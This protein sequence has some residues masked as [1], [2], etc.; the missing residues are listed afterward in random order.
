MKPFPHF[1]VFI[2]AYH[3]FV[4]SYPS[5]GNFNQLVKCLDYH[6]AND[7]NKYTNLLELYSDFIKD[8]ILNTLQRPKVGCDQKNSII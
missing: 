1:A 7:A 4:Q 8:N 6:I 5:E 2:S 3:T